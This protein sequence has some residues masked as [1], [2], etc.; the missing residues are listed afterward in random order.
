MLAVKRLEKTFGLI[1]AVRDVSFQVARGEILGFL[2]PNGAGKTTTMRMI[3]GFLPPTA[4]TA[5]VM[6]HDII[7]EPIPAKKLIGYLPENA[8]VY[9]DMTVWNYLGFIAEIRGFTGRARAGRVR[10]TIETCRLDAVT[11]Q[12]I[13][14]LSKG[15]KQRVCFAQALLHD[16][17][18][19]IMD[20]PTDGLDPNQKHVVR[21]MIRG[22][23]ARKAIVISTHILEEVEAICTRVIIIRDGAI[24]ANASPAELKAKSRM[25]GA[26]ELTFRSAPGGLVSKLER[27]TSAARVEINPPSPERSGGQAPDLSRVVREAAGVQ[28]PRVVV[29]PRSPAAG[30]AQLVQE[31]LALVKAGPELELTAI[32]T[33]EGRLDDVFRE[34]TESKD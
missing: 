14:T 5:I 8:P 34:L 10:Q 29:Y 25:H 31:I 30:P 16:P 21:T 32:K 12:A 11:H 23:A 1:H 2:G 17:P 13:G 27:L 4:G 9:A 20:E 19:L 28:A 15:Y 3:T 22:M 24:V 6:G 26:V 33:M 18:V 7:N